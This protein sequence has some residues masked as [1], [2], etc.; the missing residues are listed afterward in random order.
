MPSVKARAMVLMLKASERRLTQILFV[1][2]LLLLSVLNLSPVSAYYEQT[3]QTWEQGRFIRFHGLTPWLNWLW[4]WALLI[5]A[6][7]RLRHRGL[8]THRL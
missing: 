6:G 3:M 4:P 1:I 5:W 7:W 8:Q 2:Q